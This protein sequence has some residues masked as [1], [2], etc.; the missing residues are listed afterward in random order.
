MISLIGNVT[1][2]STLCHDVDLYLYA[3]CSDQVFLVSRVVAYCDR[4]T[5]APD[6]PTAWAVGL[7][8][9]PVGRSLGHAQVSWAVGRCRLSAGAPVVRE[10]AVREMKGREMKVREMKI[11]TLVVFATQLL[12]RN[13]AAKA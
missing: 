8:L 1:D 9:V 10:M 13:D 12:S 3:E 7:I 2:G 5:T 4:E 11:L 6:K